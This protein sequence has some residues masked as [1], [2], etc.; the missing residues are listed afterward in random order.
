M[1]KLWKAVDNYVNVVEFG[2]SVL[3]VGPIHSAGTHKRKVVLVFM[4]YFTVSFRSVPA[5][6]LGRMFGYSSRYFGFYSVSPVNSTLA[7]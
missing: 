3:F 2:K 7:F 1:L 6:D 5:M 4:Q